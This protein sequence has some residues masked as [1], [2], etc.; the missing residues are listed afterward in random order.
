MPPKFSQDYQKIGFKN[1]YK[2]KKSY[3]EIIG[4]NYVDSFSLSIENTA[5]YLTVLS[6][7][8]AAFL[9][10]TKSKLFPF[11]GIFS[12]TIYRN[13]N[14]FTWNDVYHPRL[15]ETIKQYKQFKYGFQNGLCLVTKQDGFYIN[16]HF[17]AKKNNNN[18]INNYFDNKQ[19]YQEM[20]KHCYKLVRHIYNAHV[21]SLQA[22]IL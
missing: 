2:F 6:C 10:M 8:P 15:T 18:L 4:L 9:D 22:P 13:H 5:G 3:Q 14:M 16:C 7:N 21:G 17:I 12:P 20:G 11:D 19:I 1:F